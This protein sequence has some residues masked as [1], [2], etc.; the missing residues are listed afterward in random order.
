[1]WTIESIPLIFGI[2]FG[3]NSRQAHNPQRATPLTRY[4]A[5][6]SSMRSPARVA[7]SLLLAVCCLASSSSEAEDGAPKK[8]KMHILLAT[9]CYGGLVTDAY[10][11]SVVRSYIHYQNNPNVELSSATVPGIADLPKARGALIYQFL[12]NPSHTHVLF[13]DADIEFAPE[14][15]ERFAASGHDLVTGIYPKKAIHWDNVR[16]HVQ[17]LGPEGARTLD[18]KVLKAVALDYPIAGLALFTNVIVVRQNTVQL[19]T[20]SAAHVTNLTPG[21]ECSPTRGSSSSRMTPRGWTRRA[22][23]TRTRTASRACAAPAPAS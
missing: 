11:L 3:L 13:V 18:M 9:P 10:H 19:M 1:L 23:C 12:Q 14:M 4:T 6:A 16:E 5:A 15:L 2:R 7:A 20:A 21:S 8:K 17:K 22:P